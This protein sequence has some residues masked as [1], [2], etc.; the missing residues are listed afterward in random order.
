MDEA[1]RIKAI[2]QV[3]RGVGRLPNGKVTKG[4]GGPPFYY[5]ATMGELK[6]LME[7]ALGVKLPHPFAQEESSDE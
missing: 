5:A 1:M 3:L 4:W 2:E 6:E 7:G